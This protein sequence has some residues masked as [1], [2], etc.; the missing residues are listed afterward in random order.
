M[1]ILIAT[2]SYGGTVTTNYLVSLLGLNNLLTKKGIETSLSLISFAQVEKTRNYFASRLLFEGFTHLLFID[3]DTGFSPGAVLSMIELDE[4][5]V[6]AAY[7]KRT[8]NF[9]RAASVYRSVPDNKQALSQALE[10]V[11]EGQMVGAMRAQANEGGEVTL[12]NRK[13]IAVDKAGTGLMLIKK[14]VVQAM[15]EKYPDLM[16]QKRTDP[17]SAFGELDRVF[18]CFEAIKNNDNVFMSED[19]SFCHRWT[20]EMKGKIW[21]N[22]VDPISHAGGMVFE[23]AFVN[24]FG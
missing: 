2:P 6:G 20:H 12:R 23:S 7:P 5:V 18:Q 24:R 17:Y 16:T 11:F 14:K 21:V 9:D 10:F 22:V 8:I 13:F 4:D 1:H 3:S 15:A 19:A